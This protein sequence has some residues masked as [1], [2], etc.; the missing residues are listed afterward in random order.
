M[1]VNGIKI[2][3]PRLVSLILPI[4]DET[5]VQFLFRALNDDDDFEK[6]MPPPVAPQRLMKGG[7]RLN[8]FNDP[9]Y[10]ASMEKYS[11]LKYSWSIL[12]SMDATEGLEF[13]TVDMAN[14]DTWNNWKVEFGKMFGKN[15]ANRVYFAFAEANCLSEAALDE[16]RERFL[17]SR[18]LVPEAA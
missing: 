6:V 4:S 8:D 5:S 16:A 7:E 1:K 3:K 2:E 9:G 14:S 10:V 18:Q 17:A 15:A 11:D 13:E 12:K